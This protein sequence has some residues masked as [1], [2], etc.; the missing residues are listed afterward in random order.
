MR[1]IVQVPDGVRPDTPGLPVLAMDESV[2]EDGYALVIDELEQGT[3]Q[4]FWK[5]YYGASAEMV[6]AGPA[7]AGLRKELLAVAPGC[8]D[9]PAVHAFLRAF[10]RMCARARRLHHSLHVIAD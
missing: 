7:L 9:R 3:L 2:W 8:T 10:A 4:T 1:R 5:H 6:I